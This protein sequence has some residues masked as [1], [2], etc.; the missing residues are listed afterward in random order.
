MPS[1]EHR[2]APDALLEVARETGAKVAYLIPTF[3]N[4]T[5]RTMPA[6]RRAALA[7]AAAEAGLWLVEDDPYSA[8]R[9][10]GEDVDLLAAYAPER[11]IVVQTLSK[12]LSPGLRI[13]YVRAPAALRGPL[14]VAKQAADLHTSTVAQM[15]AAALARRRTTSASTSPGW[16]RTTGRAATRCWPACASSCP[17]AR[18]LHRARG[19]PVHL[20]ARCPDGYDAAEILPRAIERGVAFVP[21]EYFYAGEPVPA[22]AAGLVRHRHAGRAARGRRPS[23][24]GLL[25]V[26]PGMPER[27]HPDMDRVRDALRERDED[28][29]E[30]PKRRPKR[31]AVRGGRWRRVSSAAAGRSVPV[32]GMGTWQTL[33]V[34]G[35]RD[36]VVHAALDA[37]ATFLDTSPMYGHAQRVLAH[38]LRGPPRR[39]VRRR[40][41]L[42]APTTTKPSEQ[43]ALLARAVRPRRP[44]PGPQPRPLARAADAARAPARR[45]Q[46]GVIGAT[47]YSASAF[48]ELAEVMRTGRIGAIQIPYNPLPA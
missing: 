25:G 45:G 39:G 47:H 36:E 32:V 28:V 31:S 5:G 26:G 33:D 35:T 3:Q 46:V 40:Q 7:A 19:R 2:A 48:D 23:R 15:A 43:A 44:L 1:D 42:D 8:L 20:G 27:P 6:A 41:A 38:G 30:S 34:R 18:V 14:A 10:E 24:R 16:P 22:H 37:G 4:P 13:G 21:G 17:R 12:V 29:P 11:T 9:L